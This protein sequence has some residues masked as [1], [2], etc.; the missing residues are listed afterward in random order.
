LKPQFIKA[1]FLEGIKAPSI[2]NTIVIE[3]M[4]ALALPALVPKKKKKPTN[5]RPSV[6]KNHR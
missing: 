5:A 3:P 4:N 2:D 1:L 6:G